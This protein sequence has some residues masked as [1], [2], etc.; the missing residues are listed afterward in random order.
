[1]EGQHGKSCLT[2]DRKDLF[3]RYILSEV[4]AGNEGNDYE[5]QI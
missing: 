2:G 1:M 4:S 5:M 3:G